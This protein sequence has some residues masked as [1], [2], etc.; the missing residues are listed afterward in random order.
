MIGVRHPAHRVLLWLALAGP[1]AGLGACTADGG[2]DGGPPP[3]PQPSAVT[4]TAFAEPPDGAELAVAETGFSVSPYEPDESAELLSYG[5]VIE[6][7]SA[8]Y[9]ALDVA[10]D[11]RLLDADGHPIDEISGERADD[12]EPRRQ[13]ITR[14]L[15]GEQIGLGRTVPHYG[16][17]VAD[18][19]VDVEA[20]SWS[21]VYDEFWWSHPIAA[22]DVTTQDT[23]D[24]AVLRF[25]VAAAYTDD[26]IRGQLFIG[27]HFTA[28]FR[29]GS[30]AVVGGADCCHGTSG[31]V[32]V[33]VPPG[34]SEGQLTIEHG[35]PAQADETR[36]EVYLPDPR[37]NLPG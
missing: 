6:N 30:G 24:G 4:P 11:I 2:N 12:P 35:P 13:S 27:G 25:A 20:A 18:L 23:G 10:V 5:V 21:P 32:T 3:S 15:P 33:E 1:V 22:S 17:E 16:S 8:D 7:P 28:V 26:T 14:L 34:R 9:L 31:I 36:T 37:E 19:E 29:D